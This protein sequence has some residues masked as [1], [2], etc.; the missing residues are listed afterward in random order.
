MRKLN[1]RVYD[2]GG[3]LLG[4]FNGENSGRIQVRDG[5]LLFDYPDNTIL[6]YS[7]EYAVTL[8]DPQFELIKKICSDNFFVVWDRNLLR[9]SW[10]YV[11]FDEREGT[12]FVSASNETDDGYEIIDFDKFCNILVRFV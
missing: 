7:Q 10:K 2:I 5:H 4:R 9:N 11:V 6:P 1:S 12:L 3:N 8:T